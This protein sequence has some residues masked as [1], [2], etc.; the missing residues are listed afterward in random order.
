MSRGE[1]DSHCS[2]HPLSRRAAGAPHWHYGRTSLPSGARAVPHS[3]RAG[4]WIRSLLRKRWNVD[5]GGTDPDG[6]SG[7]TT[8]RGS[9]AVWP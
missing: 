9:T 7:W 3:P 1:R 2:A 6:R 5:N 8:E 4:G